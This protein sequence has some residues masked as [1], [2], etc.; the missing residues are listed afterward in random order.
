[1]L[2]AIS[3]AQLEPFTSF[4]PLPALTLPALTEQI[5]IFLQIIIIIQDF[6]V[7]GG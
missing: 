4:N 6:E 5:H 7:G 1:M 2:R 3:T